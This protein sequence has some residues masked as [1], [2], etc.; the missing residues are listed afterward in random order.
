M[1]SL[2]IEQIDCIY[3]MDMKHKM[4][5]ELMDQL[6]TEYAPTYDWTDRPL[7]KMNREIVFLDILS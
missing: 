7:H 3:V 5:I 4:H 1:L 6:W 2:I